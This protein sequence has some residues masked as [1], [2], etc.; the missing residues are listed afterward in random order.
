MKVRFHVQVMGRR[1]GSIHPCHPLRKA[2]S[3]NTAFVEELR[4]LVLRVTQ[5]QSFAK[6]ERLSTLLVHIC[7]RSLEGKAKELNE[8]KIGVAVFGRRPDYD[9]SADGIV[10]DASESAPKAA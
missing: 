10:R 6:S 1:V 7:D 4:A 8:Q 9:S 3:A 5:S 2:A